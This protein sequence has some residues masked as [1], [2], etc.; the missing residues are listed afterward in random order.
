MTGPREM[1]DTIA[2][3]PTL[4]ID[5]LVVL[6]N[7]LSDLERDSTACAMAMVS[8]PDAMDM[9]AATRA[10]LDCADVTVAAQRVLSRGA[11]TSIP[12][13]R[14]VLQAALAAADRCAEECGHHAEHHAHCRVHVES[15]RQAAARCRAELD[16]LPR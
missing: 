2:V 9:V 3:E 5:D 11:A 7:A 13:T 14:A 6:L 10:A 4:E 8:E 15:A 1:L 12:V 16:M